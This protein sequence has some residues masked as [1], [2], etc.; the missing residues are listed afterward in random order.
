MTTL[1][2][3][4]DRP[5]LESLR[6]QAKRLARDVAAGNAAA[7]T[8]VRAQLAHIHLPLSQRDAQWVLAREYGFAGW[9]DLRAETLKRMGEGLDW[10]L[11]QAE[12]AIHDNDVGRLKELLAA[13][14][15]LISLR[16][17]SGGTLLGSTLSFGDS[18]DPYREQMFNRPEC[19]E[20]LID[21]GAAVER[22]V[23]VHVL[24]T[25]AIG[26]LQLL[27]RKGVLP[28]ELSILAALGDYEA[29][30]M[31]LNELPGQ[32]Q[33]APRADSLPHSLERDR[34]KAIELDDRTEVGDAFMYACRFK[35]EEIASTLLE[36][37]IALDS[38]LGRRISEWGSRSDFIQYLIENHVGHP[39]TTVWRMFVMR[40]VT[41]AIH[42]NDL[43]A[44]ERWLRSDASLLSDSFVNFQVT[45]LEQAAWG[46][47]APFI[48]HLLA[49]E[50][51]LLRSPT[52][53]KSAALEYALEY[54]NAHLI[55]L[56]TRVWSL[57]D[58]L[59][60]A[61]GM[62]DFERV[63]HWF[64]ESGRPALGHLTDHYPINDP[65]KRGHL[66][67]GAGN[68]QHVLDVA[69]AWSCMNRHLD[70]AEFLLA[71]GANINTTWSTHEPASILHECAFRDNYDAVRFLIAHGID[72]TIRDHRWNATAEGWA[73]NAAKNIPMA[74]F[75]A[76]AER[77]RKGEG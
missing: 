14:P 39:R 19:A 36:R 2:V 41:G 63:K 57:P 60:H 9:Q 68:I 26:M 61:A 17:D 15:A 76:A 27:W 73:Y 47:R 49:L 25:G 3:L 77:E 8:R 52:P 20:V 66:H 75:L 1:K 38:E 42:A 10:A 53:P 54:G 51:A 6:K 35:R 71:H 45:M 55:P 12:R 18:A 74:D 50:P 29:V 62:G 65:R 70:I 58:D 32:P 34:A 4:P 16:D 31:G 28:H 72:L 21:A 22:D 46:D 30:R 43:P 44:F 23:W 67:W 69:L 64:D 59:P 11:D 24:D 33:S 7:L 5:S 56:L 37:C 13:Y 40:Q 48:T